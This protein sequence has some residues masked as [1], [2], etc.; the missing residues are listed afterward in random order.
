MPVVY[1]SQSA[2]TGGDRG[3]EKLVMPGMP[4][5]P[6][7]FER[8]GWSSPDARVLSLVRRRIPS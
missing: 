8:L 7:V 1:G 5:D 4:G 2:L 3:Y 6:E